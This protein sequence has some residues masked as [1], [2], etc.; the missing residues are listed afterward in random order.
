MLSLPYYG[1]VSIG[2]DLRKSTSKSIP[3]PV[4]FDIEKIGIIF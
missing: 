1:C 3:K 4:T 2:F